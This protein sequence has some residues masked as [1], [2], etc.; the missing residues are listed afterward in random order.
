[1]NTVKHV[2]LYCNYT[3][4]KTR[5]F[6]HLSNLRIDNMLRKLLRVP[7]LKYIDAAP[8][9][10]AFI[11]FF[12]TQKEYVLHIV[13]IQMGMKYDTEH[14]EEDGVHYHY[15]KS[16]L[17]VILKAMNI[18]FGT[19]RKMG[20]PVYQRRF[21]VALKGIDPDAVMICGAENPD[22]ASSF[23]NNECP[24]KLVILQTLMNDPKRIA[25]GI[26]TDYRR[27]IEKKV[28]LHANHFAVPDS[29]WI[30]YVKS[31]NPKA[32]CHPFTFPTIEPIVDKETEKQYDFVFFAGL[33]G[34]NKGTNDT[35]AAL[36]IVA[37]KYP[38]VTLNIIGG[39]NEPY[40]VELRQQIKDEGI[41]KNI[42]LTP[43]FSVREDVFKQVVKSG[44]AVLPG[45]TASLNSTIRE[46]MLMGMPTITYETADT[47]KINQE[48]QCILTAKMED[49]DD[50][51]SKM[52]YA[53]INPK[54][55]NTI[56]ENG[57]KYAK[58][59]FSQ[60]SFNNSISVILRKAFE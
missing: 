35:V 34:R 42:I 7:E 14:F 18:L 32:I 28:I 41:E 19:H 5:S 10:E 59:H 31:V 11:K 29:H 57:E 1:M 39:A 22:Y 4:G 56:A 13:A 47:I 48:S 55:L 54:G 23:L 58:T 2:F 51:A 26:S 44:C 9:I 6:L 33:L 20:F 3:S 52:E 40:M 25:M 38:N 12:Q 24:K 8:W 30:G 43:S 16:G 15:V 53:V 21:K 37:K 36:G 17:G 49:I 27:E 46:V 60:E 45:I 50:L